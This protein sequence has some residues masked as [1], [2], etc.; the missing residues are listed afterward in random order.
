MVL[1]CSV[2]C[3]CFVDLVSGLPLAPAAV[4]SSSGNPWVSVLYTWGL[5]QV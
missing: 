5:V 3:Q 1:F 4:T 2:V